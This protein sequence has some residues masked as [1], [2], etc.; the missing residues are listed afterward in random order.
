MSLASPALA[1]RFFIISTS[2]KVLGLLVLLKKDWGILQILRDFWNKNLSELGNLKLELVCHSNQLCLILCDPWTVA[3]QAPLSMGFLRQEYW[4]GLPFPSPGNLPDPGIELVR[5]D[6]SLSWPPVLLFMPM[7][8]FCFTVLCLVAQ[9]RPTLCDPIDC[10]PPGS[11][12]HGN[13][14]G[15]NTKVGCHALF[16]FYSKI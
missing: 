9:S 15:K 5:S 7:E 16:L 6:L 14:P 2:W 3:H 10:S 8:S 11:S 1:G 13:S 12:V 4:S